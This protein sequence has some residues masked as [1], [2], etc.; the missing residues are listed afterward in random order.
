M[1]AVRAHL[2]ME[3]FYRQYLK[4]NGILF[5]TYTHGSFVELR[6]SLQERFR[7]NRVHF[8]VDDKNEKTVHPSML[9]L[10]KEKSLAIVKG[11]VKSEQCRMTNCR[12][13]IIL[14]F[15]KNSTS[16]YL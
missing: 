16:A 1:F 14:E 13:E 11:I 3:L 8:F 5:H 10:P 4:T 12:Q 2:D 7:F 9:R 15:T 6:W